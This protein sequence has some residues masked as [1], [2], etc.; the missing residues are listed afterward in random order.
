MHRQPLDLVDTRLHDIARSCFEDMKT[1]F[2]TREGHVYIYGGS[3]HGGWE[4]ALTNVFVPGDRVLV[5]EV[6]H[7]AHQWADHAR[8]LGLEV[9]TLTGDWREAVDPARV[10][11]HLRQDT[12]RRIKGVLMVQIDTATGVTSDVLAV[13]QAIDA[14]KHPAL[15]LVDAVASLAAMPFEMDAWGVDVAMT[16]SQKALMCPPGLTLLAAS[17]RAEEVSRSTPRYQRYWDWGYRSGDDYYTKFCGTI[18]EHHFFALRASLDL[19]ARR[20]LPEIFRAQRRLAGAVQTA[21]QTWSQAGS[22]FLNAVIPEQRAVTVTTV[23]TAPGIDANQLRTHAREK[24]GLI[25]AGGHGHLAG[26]AVR[27]GHMGSVNE[28]MVLGCLATFELAMLELG[29]PFEK[30]GVGA[31]VRYLADARRADAEPTLVRAA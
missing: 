22:L 19:I 29:I 31:A 15:F 24:L 21:V 28:A 8:A 23:C 5:V 11:A 17:K 27:I 25:V 16:A 10:E 14:A 13:R 7:F 9:D 20:G 2:G 26:H 12:E 4:A 1:V 30:D 6:G 18:P 3:G